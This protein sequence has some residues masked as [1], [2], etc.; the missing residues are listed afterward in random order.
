[1]LFSECFHPR[2]GRGS[3]S[4]DPMLARP[5]SSF[6]LN[7]NCVVSQPAGFE[8]REFRGFVL[9]PWFSNYSRLVKT[10]A[11]VRRFIL[12]QNGEL[13]RYGLTA[14]EWADAERILIQQAQFEAFAKEIQ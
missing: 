1:M 6:L 9:S 3:S 4:C 10:A 13:K 2:A 8:P 14:T 12:G 7:I 11:W 5:S